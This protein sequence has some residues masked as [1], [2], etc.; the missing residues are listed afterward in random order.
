MTDLSDLGYV[1]EEVFQSHKSLNEAT[2]GFREEV[3]CN[4]V[5]YTAYWSYFNRG[6]TC[7]L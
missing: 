1:V 7:N 5:F 3:Y 4:N 6:E 2:E